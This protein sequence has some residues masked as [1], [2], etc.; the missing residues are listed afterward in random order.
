MH[1]ELLERRLRSALRDEGDGLP[2]TI[3]AAELERRMAMRGRRSGNTRLTLLIAA[4]I[5]IGALGAVTILA[6]L[7]NKPAP[8][9]VAVAT[10]TPSSLQTSGP[11]VLPSLDDLIAS[12]PGQVL[13]AQAYGPADSPGFPLLDLVGPSLP[14]VSLGELRGGGAYR[15][16]VACLG[17]TPLEVALMPVGSSD[18]I[19]GPRFAC[20]GSV[21]DESIHVAGAVTAFIGKL[22]GMSWRVVIRGDLRQSPL[23]TMN[24]VLP[25]LP[26]GVEEL[27]RFDD[28]T[29]ESGAE[30]YGSSGLQLRAID[31]VPA[32]MFYAAQVWC[33]PRATIR[34]LFADRIEGV[35]TS[36]IEIA[37][38]CDGL[39]HGLSLPLPLPNGSPVM[40]AA[41]PSTHWSVLIGSGTPPVALA[42]DVPG[43]QSQDSTGPSLHFEDTEIS[44]SD[45][46]GE[47]GGP[48]MV[49]LECAG[50][51]QE[52]ELRA[53]VKGILGDAFKTYPARCEPGGEQTTWTFDTPATGFIISHDARAGTW[54][55]LTLLTPIASPGP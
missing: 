48:L 20:D 15:V 34:L 11:P 47:R 30:P 54:T 22:D 51:S 5:A 21:H 2:L 8:S 38:A 19:D 45:V 4:A 18:A 6:G 27:A 36:A 41:A 31:A 49:V 28:A 42:T 46:A 3:T 17:S 32:R 33:E 1:D 12:D 29:V 26:A 9:P 16:S 43:W 39:V 7:S 35:L 13:A 10:A 52:I 50:P 53:D 24:P 40:V 25:A 44:I 23:P 37:L 55:A 14:T